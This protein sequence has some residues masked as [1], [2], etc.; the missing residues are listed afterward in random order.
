MPYLLKSVKAVIRST[1][2]L[3]AL[4]GFLGTMSFA[5]FHWP[6]V[7]WFAL[8][9]I[10]ILAERYR[11]S[12]W[13][14][15]GAGILVAFFLCTF[16]FYWTVYL[17]V[18]FGGLP[19]WL[20]L[21]VF[22]AHTFF[23]NLKIPLFLLAL[24]LMRHRRFRRLRVMPLLLVPLVGLLLDRYTPQ[25]FNWYWGNVAAH[26]PYLAQVA[27]LV[28]IHGITFLYFLVTYAGYRLFPVLRH[29]V[30][31]W[32]RYGR[33]RGLALFGRSIV[34]RRFALPV[35]I[36]FVWFLY[37]VV[38]K[39]RYEQLQSQ[40]PHARV[41]ALQP[42]APLEK[43]GEHRVTDEVIRK[44]LRQTI[45]ALAEEAFR[46]AD[47]RLDL[48]VLPESAVPYYTTQDDRLTRRLGL[49]NPDFESMVVR[50]SSGYQT[51]VFFNEIA[52]G[53]SR[54]RF[55]RRPR[56]DA[57]N[58]SSVFDAGGERAGQYHKRI[59]IAF[60]EQIP[61][62]GF[63]DETGLIQLVPESIRYSRFRPGDE[64]VM[65]PYGTS[66][67]G[68]FL[69]LICYEV[70]DPGYVRDFVR[71]DSA[72]FLVNITQD[73]WYGNTIETYQHFELGRIRAI[74]TRKALVRSTN[75]GSSGMVDLAGNYAR[76]LYGPTFTEQD[77]EAVQIFEVPIHR[78]KP[79]VFVRFGNHWM[80]FPV[81]LF[82]LVVLVRR[83]QSGTG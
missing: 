31:R 60:G 13:K 29:A 7:G 1:L 62:A 21:I 82:I 75:S 42:N 34:L 33:P 9:P 58:S 10:F 50:L 5:P 67:Q 56:I 64:F 72:D 16:A 36:L 30:R 8:W 43:Y 40:L 28:G 47:G 73:R 39:S 68:Q 41:A 81:L 32:L 48:I 57:Y 59:L 78:N 22:A 19:V 83:K 76:P 63:L 71:S 20:A 25:I 18:V 45:P 23:L 52:V 49:Y 15:I 66:A 14:M 79:T 11:H 35:V 17:F 46:R 3:S 2:F 69:P 24:G 38:Q 12:H 61:M 77:V 44:L 54:D 55:T 4:S 74:E 80:W 70:L 51:P 53:M 6:V 65:L 27:D 37:G 26:N